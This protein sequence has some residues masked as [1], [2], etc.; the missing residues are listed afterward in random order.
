MPATSHV[1]AS[2]SGP[3]GEEVAVVRAAPRH[4]DLAR[5]PQRGAPDE[6]DAGRD[7]RVV[8]GEAGLVVVGS[9]DQDVGAGEQFAGGGDREQ[10]PMSDDVRT[11]R[12]RADAGGRRVDLRASDVRGAVQDLPMQVRLIDQVVVDDGDRADARGGK[13]RNDRAAQ[14]ARADDDRARRGQ[15]LLS[16]ALRSR[17][18]S[19]DAHSERRADRAYGPFR[20]SFTD[21]AARLRPRPSAANAPILM[22]C[23]RGCGH[24]G[25]HRAPGGDAAR[26]ERRH[27]AA[28]GRKRPS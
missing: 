16:S 19:S 9:V 18:G 14:T 23:E 7:G 6:G 28:L 13:D 24:E 4:P 26:G 20:D 2:A 3:V 27:R 10:S 17:E 1:S 8:G 22:T 12:L 15:N 25:V 11:R 21:S 5:P